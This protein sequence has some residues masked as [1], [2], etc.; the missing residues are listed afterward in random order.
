MRVAEVCNTLS[1][2]SLCLW[3]SMEC[4]YCVAVVLICLNVLL[5]L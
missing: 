2:T 5:I 1:F 3:T 4:A